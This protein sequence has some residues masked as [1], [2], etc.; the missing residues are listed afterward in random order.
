MCGTYAF[1][2]LCAYIVREFI[3]CWSILSEVKYIL[4]LISDYRSARATHFRV[5]F[6]QTITVKLSIKGAG[7]L[8]NFTLFGPVCLWFIVFIKISLEF[9]IFTAKCF[10]FYRMRKHLWCHHSP[11]RAETNVRTARQQAT[12]PLSLVRPSTHATYLDFIKIYKMLIIFL[13]R[14]ADVH[15][16]SVWIQ[17]LSRYPPQRSVPHAEDGRCPHTL[18]KW[19][20]N[21]LGW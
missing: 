2:P 4:A 9:S 15:S 12:L 14:P 18:A 11:K 13:S 16:F 6:S 10:V 21:L 19:W 3:T 5:A 8:L 17:E 7:S 20:V 1:G